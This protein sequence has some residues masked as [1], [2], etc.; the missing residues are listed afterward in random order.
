[1]GV[2]VSFV[3]TLLIL[4]LIVYV[5][6]WLVSML[7]LPEPIRVILMLIVVIVGIMQLLTYVR[8]V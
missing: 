7:G 8:L 2:L 1:M 3:L 4:V 6:Q 5:I